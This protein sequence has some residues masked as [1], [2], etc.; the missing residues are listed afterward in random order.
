LQEGC[1]SFC[2]FAWE[3]PTAVQERFFQE[4]SAR[5]FFCQIDV[6]SCAKEILSRELCK[7]FFLPERCQKQCKRNSFKRVVQ[8]RFFLPERCPGLHKIYCCP[9]NGAKKRFTYCCFIWKFSKIIEQCFWNIFYTSLW[10]ISLMSLKFLS[11]FFYFCLL[12]DHTA[13]SKLV[14]HLLLWITHGFNRVLIWLWWWFK[15]TMAPVLQVWVQRSIS[16]NCRLSALHCWY[17]WWEAFN[18]WLDHW[19]EFVERAIAILELVCW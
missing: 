6:K 13:S 9:D 18:A 5:M 10:T 1:V 14:V 17:T 4:S 3:M 8:E 2:C 7:R 11:S 19:H 16:G 12:F 15:W